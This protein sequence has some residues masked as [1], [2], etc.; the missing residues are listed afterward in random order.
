MRLHHES[1]KAT[2]FYIG[3]LD[4]RISYFR[5]NLCPTLKTHHL[6]LFG[7]ASNAF[8]TINQIMKLFIK[9]SNILYYDLLCDNLIIN[10]IFA[11]IIYWDKQIS[12]YSAVMISYRFLTTRDHGDALKT[13]FVIC[14][15]SAHETRNR[16][17]Y[18]KSIHLYRQSSLI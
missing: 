11:I 10:I 4:H 16:C 2:R 1:P 9:F 5:F 14:P 8:T 15:T 3:A 6:V 13:S 17:N 12:E 7:D 18:A